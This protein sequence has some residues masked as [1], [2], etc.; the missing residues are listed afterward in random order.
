MNY[1]A[2]TQKYGTTGPRYTSYPTV[3]NW[4]NDH[5]STKWL[6][7]IEQNGSQ[8]S[9]YV[10]LPYCESFCTYCGCN[11]VLTKNH[12]LESPY[13]DLVKKEWDLYKAKL[14]EGYVIHDIHLGGGT[15]TF[16]SPENLAD[17]IK[18]LLEGSQLSN[19]HE[20]SFEAH[21]QN[22]SL[23]HLNTLYNLGFR[24]LSLGIQDFEP[25]VQE[26]INRFQTYEEV[27]ILV[28]HARLLGYDSVNFDLIYGLPFQ[29]PESIEK[30]LKQAITLRP[31]RVA[32]YGYAH[33]PW[34]A[35]VQR[36]FTEDDLPKGIAR[37]ELQ[38]IGR[39]SFLESGYVEI[40]MDHF[41]LKEDSLAQA[42]SKGEVHRNFMGYTTHP[43]DTLI[44]LGVSSIGESE[45]GYVQNAKT[46]RSYTEFIERGELPFINGHRYTKEELDTKEHI[47]DLMCRLETS[48]PTHLT[49]DECKDMLSEMVNDNLVVIHPDRIEV[50]KE[51]IPFIRNICMQID[52]AFTEVT[53]KVYSSTV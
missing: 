53:G 46:I 51:G 43:G 52:P 9:L 22:T 4:K 3:P 29:T 8:I 24:R 38:N 20:F 48:I 40:G 27:E 33:V 6:D 30:T 35:K 34:K 36:L 2:L 23:E 28:N 10:H 25:K 44:G 7:F 21:P 18:Y 41:V 50:L 19:D 11:K 49:V 16:F 32:Y 26:A 5:T 37:L 12:D 14:P 31:D 47:L 45:M 39:T 42:L 1:Q 15:P 13:I 17:L